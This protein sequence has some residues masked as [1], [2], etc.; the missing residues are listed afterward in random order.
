MSC[1]TGS[2]HSHSSMPDG[3]VFPSAPQPIPNGHGPHQKAPGSRTVAPGQVQPPTRPHQSA[4]PSH[5]VLRPPAS[6]SAGLQH[7]STLSGPAAQQQQQWQHA[8]AAPEM[9]PQQEELG[10][11]VNKQRQDAHM[12]DGR[13]TSF[14][15][16]GGLL[17]IR[18][19]RCESVN[20]ALCG[21]SA[22]A[23]SRLHVIDA[24][25]AALMCMHRRS[26]IPACMAGAA[27][28]MNS[29]ANFVRSLAV[30]S[31]ADAD[32]YVHVHVV[33]D[34]GGCMLGHSNDRA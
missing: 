5:P 13:K 3:A 16:S 10:T 32:A 2:H 15:R 9:Q 30:L 21:L 23:S 11:H 19:C 27:L 29:I 14:P 33:L 24:E 12:T 26:R 20:L 8:Q 34:P 25:I 1:S 31:D 6:S 22:A 7:H 4:G 17:S 28:A 18:P